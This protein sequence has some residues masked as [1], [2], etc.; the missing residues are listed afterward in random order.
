MHGITV[1][2]RVTL[3]VEIDLDDRWGNGCSIE[4]IQKQAAESARAQVARAFE[5]KHDLKEG[6]RRVKG[7]VIGDVRVVAILAEEER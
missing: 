6:A 5:D 4:Q 2:A 3:T 7:R 1:R